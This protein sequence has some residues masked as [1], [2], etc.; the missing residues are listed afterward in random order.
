MRGCG[1]WSLRLRGEFVGSEEGGHEGHKNS[2]LTSCG[3]EGPQQHL[4]GLGAFSVCW[5][6]LWAPVFLQ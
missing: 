3:S 4:D 2:L 5:D 6:R 1:G